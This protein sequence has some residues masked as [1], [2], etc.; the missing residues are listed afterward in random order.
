MNVLITEAGGCYTVYTGQGEVPNFDFDTLHQN[1]N[2]GKLIV[3]QYFL[4]WLLELHQNFTFWVENNI[5]I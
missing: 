2:A 1:H 4:E 5:Y 3:C